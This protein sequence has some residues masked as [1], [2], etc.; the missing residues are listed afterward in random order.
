MLNGQKIINTQGIHTQMRYSIHGPDKL[1]LTTKKIT[2]KM[3]KVA[4]LIKVANK[5]FKMP[6]LKPTITM[7][8]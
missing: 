1:S 5:V 2:V 8:K 4:T 3:A 6:P 7:N